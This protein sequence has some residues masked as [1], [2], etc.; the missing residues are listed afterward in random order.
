[1]ISLF[2]IFESVKSIS[3]SEK[4][5]LKRTAIKNPELLDKLYAEGKNV[6]VLCGHYNNWEFYALSLPKKTKHT[7]YSLYQPLKNSFF[8]NIVLS[9]RKRYGMKLIETS[10]IAQFFHHT[11][12][13]LKMIVVMN[14]QS[15]INLHKSYWNTFLNQE[16]GWNTGPEK[17]AKKYDYVVLF[18]HS[19]AIK[20]G[21]YEVEFNVITEEP[22]TTN[23]DYITNKYASLLEDIIKQRPESWLWSHKRW[24]H[25]RV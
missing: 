11:S 5:V 23:N 24:K 8:N 18:G 20:R 7:A 19:K 2:R 1:M 16:T 17:F 25:K 10:N 3:I 12:D 4:E 22:Q 6:L 9:S 21:Y 14:D 13:N 15:P